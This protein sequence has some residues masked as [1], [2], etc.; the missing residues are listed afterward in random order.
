MQMPAVVIRPTP[1]DPVR[2]LFQ[3]EN[4]WW[5]AIE[6]PLARK[7]PAMRDALFDNLR[8][9]GQDAS[10]LNMRVLLD[11]VDEL[12]QQRGAGKEDVDLL[13]SRGFTPAVRA[14][15]RELLRQITGGEV[16]GLPTP[17]AA[18][19]AERVRALDDMWH[20]YQDWSR[21][22]R[23]IIRRKDL[24][25]RLGIAARARPAPALVEGA[26]P[27]ANASGRVLGTGAR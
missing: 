14:T 20:W 8:R 23:T 25:I 11:R 10:V 22:A 4:E 3:L 27:V 15:G 1:D 7:L 6:A 26:L 12:A 18:A 21:T 13:E 9:A 16:P 19:E 5:E 24:R 17:D 2:R